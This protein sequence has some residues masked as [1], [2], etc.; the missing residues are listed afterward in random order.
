MISKKRTW[1]DIII[2]AIALVISALLIGL[3]FLPSEGD[4]T[5]SVISEGGESEYSLSENREIELMSNGISLI[6]RIE[7]SSAYILSSECPNGICMKQGRA[8][9]AGDTVV[10]APAGVA[11]IIKSGGVSHGDAVAG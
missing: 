10:C 3:K 1:L 11:L 6:I 5:L 2:I 9:R 7:N 4:L 8:K